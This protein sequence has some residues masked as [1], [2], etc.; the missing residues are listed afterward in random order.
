MKTP[1]NEN[2]GQMKLRG[3]ILLQLCTTEEWKTLRMLYSRIDEVS[4]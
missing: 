1:L 2:K 4:S 3:I